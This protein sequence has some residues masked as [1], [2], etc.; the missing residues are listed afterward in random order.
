LRRAFPSHENTILCFIEA[1]HIADFIIYGV[2]IRR[3]MLLNYIYIFILIDTIQ[4]E[5]LS[6]CF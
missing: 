6:I 3:L 5:Q 4:Q 2:F 1:F